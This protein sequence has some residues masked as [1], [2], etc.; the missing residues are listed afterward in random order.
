MGYPGRRVLS[1]AIVLFLTMTLSCAPLRPVQKSVKVNSGQGLL[2]RQADRIFDNE[3]FIKFF[4]VFT[5]EPDDGRDSHLIPNTR[6]A[7]YKFPIHRIKRRQEFD[8]TITLEGSIYI[9]GDASATALPL[10]NR[11]FANAG[12]LSRLGTRYVVNI[13][14]ESAPTG[15]MDAVEVSWLNKTELETFTGNEGLPNNSHDNKMLVGFTQLGSN[16]VKINPIYADAHSMKSA[17]SNWPIN[18]MHLRDVIKHTRGVFAHE[19]VHAMG[20]SHMR[21]HTKSMASY[22][23]ARSVN[24]SDAHAI[25]LLITNGDGVLCPE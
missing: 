4:S 13:R 16:T 7:G 3:E 9:H 21:N 5:R 19:I 20:L 1:T 24:G 18:Q 2:S 12:G 14:F 22:A 15:S 10:L 11:F 17:F 25:C 23:S 6:Q 8:K